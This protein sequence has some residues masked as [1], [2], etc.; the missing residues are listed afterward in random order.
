MNMRNYKQ[1]A[2]TMIQSIVLTALSIAI[3]FGLLFI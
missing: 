2:I 3:M 1:E